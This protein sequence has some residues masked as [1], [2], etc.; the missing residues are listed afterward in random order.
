MT[1]IYIHI[2][3]NIQYCTMHSRTRHCTTG[4]QNRRT[5]LRKQPGEAAMANINETGAPLAGHL[6]NA[7]VFFPSG[8]GHPKTVGPPLSTGN[9]THSRANYTTRG[10]LSRVPSKGHPHASRM[11]CTHGE[12]IPDCK[13][14][15]KQWCSGISE[16]R[17][18]A[19][20]NAE[21]AVTFLVSLFLEASTPNWQSL[22]WFRNFLRHKI[23]QK[24]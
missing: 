18:G 13:L 20:F 19:Y 16:L 15:V 4:D 21:L 14:F 7:G 24:R 10:H 6:Q 9:D 3:Y 12:A 8:F 22:C 1:H 5:T 23:V 11:G 2:T 17:F